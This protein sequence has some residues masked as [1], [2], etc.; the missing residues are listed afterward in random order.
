MLPSLTHE[1]LTKRLPELCPIMRD[2][3]AYAL[4]TE[5]PDS[6]SEQHV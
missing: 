5:I 6:D 2:E 4:H 3:A 1:K